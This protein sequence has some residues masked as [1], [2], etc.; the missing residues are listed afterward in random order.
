MT[1]GVSASH[2]F[3]GSPDAGMQMTRISEDEPDRG[4]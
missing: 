2:G 3:T 4:G 1:A